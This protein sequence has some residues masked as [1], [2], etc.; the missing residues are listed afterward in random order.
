MNRD[1]IILI[2]SIIVSIM[3]MVIMFLL[4]YILSRKRQ[5]SAST[6]QETQITQ[7]IQSIAHKKEHVHV[8]SEHNW[9]DNDYPKSIQ[10]AHQWNKEDCNR[11]RTEYVDEVIT[12]E[13]EDGKT[14]KETGIGEDEFIVETKGNDLYCYEK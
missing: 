7:S 10:Q 2:L 4:I 11:R 6:M 13:G 3:C 9:V 1:H 14:A 5:R 8:I 12:A